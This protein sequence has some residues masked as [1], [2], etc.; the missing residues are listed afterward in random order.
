MCLSLSC[1]CCSCRQFSSAGV[2]VMYFLMFALA[3][4]IA[5]LMRSDGLQ[6]ALTKASNSTNGIIDIACGGAYESE[7]VGILASY[8]IV[9][10]YVFFHTILLVLTLGSSRRGDVQGSLH[11]SW[12]PLKFL[13]LAA[14]MFAS[15]FISNDTV[16]PF[17]WAAFSFSIV[18]LL[19]QIL[20][21]LGTAYRSSD[22]I[23]NK[24]EDGS[25]CTK[26]M[27][28]FISFV[29]FAAIITFTVVMYVYFTK[30][31]GCGFNKAFISINLVLFIIAA[32]ISLLPRVQEANA[33]ANILPV[34]FLGS[35]QTYL[36]WAAIAS[37][38]HD[39]ECTSIANPLKA[40]TP[41]IT[42]GMILLFV[43]VWW[44]ILNSVRSDNQTPWKEVFI[45]DGEEEA[46]K[47]SDNEYNFSLFHV[48]FIFA[49]CY[50]L[51]VL[52]SWNNFSEQSNLF[53]LNQNDA[54][55]W[56]NIIMSWL[57]WGAMVWSLIAPSCCPN[58]FNN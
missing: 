7:C 4:C 24:F 8:R 29:L 37:R 19:V 22:S 13:L 57:V 26:F 31:S 43:V 46:D 14:L 11:S 15:F 18:F 32:I 49:A 58:R 23:L 38:P 48:F 50:G 47:D 35:F 16:V 5:W 44:F 28:Y 30:P 1:C 56:A 55:F 36:C 3:L 41:S 12:W 33:S 42:V 2:R 6:T 51:M 45:P 52:S 9:L 27:T 53:Q 34:L 17:Y 21:F 10:G 25:M 39:I 40:Q 20:M 54:A